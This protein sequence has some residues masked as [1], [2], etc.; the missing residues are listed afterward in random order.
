M[1][2]SPGA[3]TRP[4]DP[5]LRQPVSPLRRRRLA[6]AG[7]GFAAGLA[8][9]LI[10]ISAVLFNGKTPAPVASE[11]GLATQGVP[12]ATPLPATTTT[13]A[14]TTT[15][16]APTVRPTAT[17]VPVPTPTPLAVAGLTINSKSLSNQGKLAF[18]FQ[19]NLF[20]L[21]GATGQARQIN[22]IGTVEKFGWSHDGEWLAYSLQPGP[23]AP[24][25][26]L[27]LSRSDGAENHQLPGSGD[28]AWSPTANEL[29][30]TQIG[31]ST[32]LQI[33]STAGGAV[34][35]VTNLNAASP[36]WSPDGSTLAFISTDRGPNGAARL[37]TVPAKGGP[38]SPVF[39]AEPGNGLTLLD[40][41]P[42]G[43]GLLF[44]TIPANSASLSADGLPVQSLSLDAPAQTPQTLV[45]SLIHPAWLSWSPDGT[46]F[47]AVEGAGRQL[48]TNKAL[49]VC[50]VVKASCQILAQP[51]NTVSLD[52]AWSPD[53]NRIAFVRAE[54]RS[55]FLDAAG[56]ADWEKTRT[57]WVSNPDGSQARPVEGLAAVVGVQNPLW[58]RDS[59]QL[60]LGH[61]GG[62]APGGL[63]L[64]G[65]TEQAGKLQ[66]NPHLVAGPVGNSAQQAAT[67]YYGYQDWQILAAWYR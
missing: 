6:L 59:K 61:V 46:K 30:L 57:L 60:L 3:K 25:N 29:A 23:N 7:L 13:A 65:L 24:V 31:D 44:Q 4:T 36:L 9:F 56:F 39:A 43:K 52:P 2:N 5:L 58:S 54:A 19:N 1:K 50:D 10:V 67:G 16:A 45:K 32:G 34:R 53:G 22:K 33:L 11:A 47:V 63:W 12:T 51:V 38:T 42:T 37:V 20:T 14:A 8:L 66:A 18:I 15:T 28:F 40:W 26:S 64:T 62:T 17:A 27:W 35:Y 48:S 49:T 21:D 55:G 41:W